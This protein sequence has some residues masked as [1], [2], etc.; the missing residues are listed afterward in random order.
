MSKFHNC[1]YACSAVVM[2][3]LT[4]ASPC[5]AQQPNGG[6]G[7]EIAS[8]DQAIEMGRKRSRF[9]AEDPVTSDRI[10]N[11]D[12]LVASVD[13]YEKTVKPILIQ[14]CIA[15]HGPE[16]A[17]G[18]LRVDKIDPDLLAGADVS[19]W[20]EIYSAISHLEMPPQD[21]Q[22]HVMTDGERSSVIEWLSGELAKASTSMRRVGSRSTFR[23][24][25]NYEYDYALQDLL[26]LP[27]SLAG[28]LP[29]EI[30]SEEGFKNNGDHLQMSVMQ[31]EIYRK[32]ALDALSRVV[33]PA[34]RPKPVQYVVEMKSELEQAIEAAPDKLFSA[35]DEQVTNQLRRSH[36]WDRS[37]QRGIPFS[38]GTWKPVTEDPDSAEQ[39]VEDESDVVLALPRSGELK[40]NLDRFLPDAGVMRV[41]LLVSRSTQ[42]PTEFASL[43]L[44]FSAHT[45]NN[46]NFMNEIS[47]SDIPVT[48]SPDQPEWIHFDIPLQDIQRNP[49]RKLET[50]FPR[51]DEFLHIRNIAN[52]NGEGNSFH[53]LIHRIEIDAPHYD[54]W[55]PLAHQ[56]LFFNDD[57][58]VDE[59]GYCRDILM[60][61]LRRVW[62]RPVR[63]EEVENLVALFDVYRQDFGRFEDA[64]LEVMATTLATPE[65]LYVTRRDSSD[66]LKEANGFSQ[67]ELARR[68]AL[69]LWSSIPD[70]QLLA[71][72]EAGELAE[73]AV[74]ERQIDRLLADPRSYRFARHFVSQWLGLDAIEATAHIKDPELFKAMKEEPIVFF[75]DLLKRNES[76]FEI[77]HSNHLM[78][79]ERL[80][81]HYGVRDVHGPA[82]RSVDI[83]QSQHRG[84]VLTAAAILAMN[85]DGKDSH[86]LKRGVWMLETILHDPPPPP[87]PNVPEVDLTD[88]RIL[89][90]TLKER[91]AD[92]RDQAACRSCHARIDPWGIAFEQYDALG[93]FRTRIEG[94]SVDATSVLYNGQT[95][96]GMDGLKRYLLSER[97]DQFAEA[98]VHKMASY[99]LG[100]NLSLAD[101]AEIESI[102][103][104]LRRNGD[105][106]AD[107]VKLIIWSDLFLQMQSP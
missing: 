41:R 12:A 34:V 64:M 71:C 13:Q 57:R 70:E 72:A 66:L 14:R 2:M 26:G 63:S 74:L 6:K 51:R 48:A 86:P 27:Y 83:D 59:R 38:N 73:P 95:L 58:K 60:R 89:E 40:M 101:H 68:L 92:H 103:G 19:Q 24:L 25:T 4:L 22:Q 31:F 76:I 84:G 96:D 30:R 50:T 15:C 17:E 80:A 77:L 23:R 11:S 56:V 90:M 62:G 9:L 88:P 5:F 75:Q 55:P 33:A 105:G 52:S 78:L 65:F 67:F 49:F 35:E 18:R 20:R 106:L 102:V 79:N 99:A 43:R 29:P 32:V 1:L 91:L 87:P 82:F 28:D 53:V 8:L 37:S 3:L 10:N 45:S 69:F 93:G 36:L 44:V 39:F 85:S 21:D 46:A 100:R 104:A 107:L 42:E 7:S 47:E 54:H 81:R 98:V 94:Q 61:F 16:E 97:Q